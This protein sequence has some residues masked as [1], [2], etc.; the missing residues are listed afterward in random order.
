MPG[1]SP[2]DPLPV[3]VRGSP[4][5]RG[6]R[7]CRGREGA[8]GTVRAPRLQPG[9]GG[10]PSRRRRAGTGGCSPAWSGGFGQEERGGTGAAGGAAGRL[11]SL[12]L[13]LGPSAGGAAWGTRP[14][15]KG[16]PARTAAAGPRR[17][18]RCR[19]AL[20][21]AR[22]LP[23]NYRAC[24]PFF[25]SFFVS[26]S[27]PV[28][29]PS[30]LPDKLNKRWKLCVCVGG[31]GGKMSLLIIIFLTINASHGTL[32]PLT[33]P[34]GSGAARLHSPLP[35]GDSPP[36]PGGYFLAPGGAQPLGVRR[37]SAGPGRRWP[38]AAAAP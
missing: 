33:M 30:L 20:R 27:L 35:K 29:F 9:R 4:A 5:S 16:C 14:L 31:A 23:I 17:E 15:G 32:P 2:R 34:C 25:L 11:R 38:G 28:T 22:L 21:C 3:L 36:P 1:S 18:G 37:G 19:G 10:A 24:F 7:G 6:R 13:P 26:F 8:V 12:G